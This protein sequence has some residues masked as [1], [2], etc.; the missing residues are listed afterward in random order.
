MAA[1][2]LVRLP[3][4]LGTAA[5]CPMTA[6]TTPIKAMAPRTHRAVAASGAHP[7]RKT[8][9]SHTVGRLLGPVDSRDSPTF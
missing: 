2:N 3:R 8:T 9:R 1:Y 7:H 4:L 5:W 6:R